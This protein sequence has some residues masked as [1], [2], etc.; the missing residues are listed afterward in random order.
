[1]CH[2]GQLRNGSVVTQFIHFNSTATNSVTSKYV[3]VP[4]RNGQNEEPASGNDEQAWIKPSSAQKMYVNETQFDCTYIWACEYE[5]F[6]RLL[7]DLINFH[8]Y[9]PILGNFLIFHAG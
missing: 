2:F 9:F 4:E 7:F 5:L 3:T 8:S 1:M 6:L